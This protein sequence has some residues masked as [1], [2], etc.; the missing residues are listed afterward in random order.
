MTR[1]VPVAVTV[2]TAVRNGERYVQ[3]S[4]RSLLDQVGPS[5]EV[6]VVDDGSTDR[7]PMLLDAVAESDPRLIVLHSRPHGFT[8]S[9]SLAVSR[10][11]GTVIARHDL[12]DL[13]LP[14]R[15]ARQFSF[16][17][18]HPEVVA[19]GTE[20]DVIDASGDRVS[21]FPTVSG[22]AAVRRGLLS[23]RAT[24]VHGSMMLRRSALDAVGGYRSAF[25]AAQDYDLWLRLIERGGVDVMPEVLYCWRLNP[26][27]VYGRRRAEQLQFAGVARMFADERRMNGHDSCER[28][29]RAGGDFEQFAVGYSLEGPLR[30]LWGELLYRG[31]NDPRLAG[32]HLRRAVTLGVLRPRTLALL[33]W[34][35]LGRP[36]PG[37]QPLAAAG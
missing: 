18:A 25:R 17:E 12:D 35:S 24:P 32:A 14:G 19:V 31:L 33:A 4:L 34:A 16:L 10:A 1:A 23:L 30:A 36:W 26:A 15:L 28:L 2:V 7:T 21:A 20:A 37:G 13:S 5:L 29:E 8:Q 22:V 6:V 9:L 11:A 27:G 3:D